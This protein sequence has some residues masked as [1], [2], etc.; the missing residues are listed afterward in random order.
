V[1]S[2]R[3]L[4]G[5]RVTGGRK[6]TRRIGKILRAVFNPETYDIAGYIVKR[7]DFIFMFKRRDRFLAFDAYQIVD[8]RVVGTTDKDS[9]DEPACKRLGID[10]ETCLI[11]EGMALVTRDGTKVGTI[12]SVEYDEV[13]GTLISLEVADGATAKAL[14]G[15]TKIPRDLIIGYKDGRVLAKRAASDIQTEGGLAAK[16]G[17]QTAVITNAVIEKTETARQAAGQASKKAG[18]AAGKA[19]DSGSKALGKQLG[20]TKGMFKA[21]KDEYKKES[22]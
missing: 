21:F 10:W 5:A 17:E 12:D 15:V 16:A 8:G 18:K 9:W 11:L 14:L 22:K 2:T 4:R 6:G 7:P 19:F 20:K 3:E 1:R 13:T